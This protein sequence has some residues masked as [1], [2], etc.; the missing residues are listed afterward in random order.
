V[1]NDYDICESIISP[2]NE[3]ECYTRT[4]NT[5]S[6]CYAELENEE[7]G[8]K[9]VCIPIEYPMMS[10]STGLLQIKYEENVYNSTITCNTVTTTCGPTIPRQNAECF[11]D[12]T[13]DIPC[14][15]IDFKEGDSIK[16]NCALGDWDYLIE[17]NSSTLEMYGNN[18]D[19]YSRVL[20]ISYFILLLIIIIINLN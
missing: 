19:C 2:N 8:N 12:S 10:L 17:I 14:C 13:A 5:F 1:I 18:I 15:Y 9:N 20:S 16:R 4:N 6:C 11:S 7:V 3:D